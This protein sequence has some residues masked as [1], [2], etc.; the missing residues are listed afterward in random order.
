MYIPE[1]QN[2]QNFATCI[3]IYEYKYDSILKYYNQERIELVW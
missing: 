1:H 2:P 3:N